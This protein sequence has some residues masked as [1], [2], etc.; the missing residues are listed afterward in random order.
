MRK[1]APFI[2]QHGVL[3]VGG[4]LQESGLPYSKRHPV[5]L[6][7]QCHLSRLV[8]EWAHQSC[9]HGGQA[10]TYAQVIQRAWI[11]GGRHKTK[12]FIRHCLKC[13]RS[14]P[15][16]STQLMGNLPAERVTRERPFSRIRLDYA[17]PFQIKASKGRG[18]RSSKSYLAIFVCLAIKAV[19]LEVVG[20]LTTECFLAAVSL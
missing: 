1:L 11:I 20:D 12:S 14:N 2:D 9:L 7:K 16:P 18:I 5:I 4:R 3:R 6:P 17:G 15:R 10:L 8:I 19:H 13:A